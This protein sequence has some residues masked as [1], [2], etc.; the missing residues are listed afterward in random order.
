MTGGSSSTR[1]TASGRLL[2]VDG[3]SVISL[4]LPTDS[5]RPRRTGAVRNTAEKALAER[6]SRMKSSSPA[7]GSAACGAA[8]SNF[9]MSTL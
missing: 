9:G 6:R 5:S 4:L 7:T 8:P 2:R 3:T 1:F